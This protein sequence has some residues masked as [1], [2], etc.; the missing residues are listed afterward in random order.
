MCYFGRWIKIQR[1]R[2]YMVLFIHVVLT[3]PVTW[4]AEELPIPLAL[5]YSIVYYVG[6]RATVYNIMYRCTPFNRKLISKFFCTN[7]V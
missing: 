5:K 7:L 1:Y 2:H 6:L 4:G 3:V